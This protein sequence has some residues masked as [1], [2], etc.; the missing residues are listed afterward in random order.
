MHAAP[1]RW[2]LG[3]K[4]AVVVEVLAREGGE[5][6]PYDAVRDAVR[7]ALRQHSWATALRQYLMLLAGQAT[8][9]GVR[10]ETSDTPLVQ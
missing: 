5:A 8:L 4:L 6:M 9:E 1:S 7:A 10:L 2:N 3:A